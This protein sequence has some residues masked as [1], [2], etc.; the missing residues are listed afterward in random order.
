MC[1]ATPGRV[2]SIK[3]R[4]ARV[5]YPGPSTGSVQGGFV[6]RAMVGVPKLKLGDWVMVQMGVVIQVMSKIDAEK[7]EKGWKDRA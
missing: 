3:G 5:E 7:L 4:E 6:R 2:K 1:I